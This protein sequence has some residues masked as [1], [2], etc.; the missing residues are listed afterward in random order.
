MAKSSRYNE[1]SVFD[2]SAYMIFKRHSDSYSFKIVDNYGEASFIEIGSEQAKRLI[3][4]L[5]DV[6]KLNG[7]LE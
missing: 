4:N 5:T 7:H 2:S 1:S 3:K 6:L